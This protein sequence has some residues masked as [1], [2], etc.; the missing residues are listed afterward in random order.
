MISHFQPIQIVFFLR[1]IFMVSFVQIRKFKGEIIVMCRELFLV[2]RKKPCD[3][4][5]RSTSGRLD[6]RDKPPTKYTP[7]GHEAEFHLRQSVVRFIGQVQSPFVHPLSRSHVRLRSG[8]RKWTEW[9]AEA[10]TFFFAFQT[11]KTDKL[12]PVDTHFLFQSTCRCISGVRGH[13]R[14]Q[15]RGEIDETSCNG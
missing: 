2:Y 11:R 6:R 4:H 3:K 5:K 13:L 8:F 15:A 9:N 7:N 14:V 10:E 12:S 1:S